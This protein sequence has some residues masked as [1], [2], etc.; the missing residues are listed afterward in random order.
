MDYSTPGLPV[1]HQ[2]LELAQTHIHW[3]G[4]AIQ[5]SHPLPSPSP[6]AFDLSQH[7][8]LFQWVSSLHQVA[9]V[10]QLQ[11]QHQSSSEYPGL[12]S[13]RIVWFDLLLAVQGTL[14]SLLQHNS[15][16]VS[17]L[18]CSAIFVVQLSYLYMTT[19]KTIA[20]TIQTFVGKVM[21]LIFNTLSRFVI[22]FLSRS[23]HLLIS[24]LQSPS[25]VILEPKKIK[26]VTDFIFPHLLGFPDSSVGK[27]SA[28]NAGDP[29]GS[30]PGQEDVLEKG[31]ATHSSILGLPWWL[32]W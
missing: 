29:G 31:W 24:W 18:W 1:H 7:Q 23:K 20:L 13:F 27:E 25:T 22:S 2:V 11:F 21:S 14:K 4:D 26:S 8:G 15:S 5:P 3:V 9:K 30:I 10:L 16:K 6:P 32:S 28:C 17:I 12:I 19:W